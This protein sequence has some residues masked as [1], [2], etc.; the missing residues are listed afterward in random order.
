MSKIAAVP[1]VLIALLGE[2]GLASAQEKVDEGKKEELKQADPVPPMGKGPAGQAGTQEPS[3][4]VTAASPSRGVFVDGKLA[5]PGAAT[6]GETV[7]SKYS[8]RNAAIDKLPTVAFSLRLT[9]A[10]KRELYEQLH[11]GRGGLALS[12]A[13]AMAGAEIPAEIALRDLKPVPESL[14][15]KF[16]ELRWT[17]FLIEGP[18]VLLANANN[19]VVV[20][21]PAQ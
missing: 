21:L 14:I 8:T 7:P 18:N 15:A 17:S 6:D 10:Q 2:Y 19:M 1:L 20:V 9:D 11:G 16:P 5:V 3:T 13:H 4:K 12:P